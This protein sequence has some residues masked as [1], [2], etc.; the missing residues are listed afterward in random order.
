M[1]TELHRAD[2]PEGTPR[3][4]RLWL[5]LVIGSAVVLGAWF[6]GIEPRADGFFFDEQI[7]MRN[8][9][10]I[11]ETGRLQPQN[12]WYQSLS[13]L[14]QAALLAASEQV[15]EAT[16]WAMF[17]VRDARGFRPRAYQ[18]CRATT[19]LFGAFSLWLTFC[20]GRRLVSARVGLLATFLLA[21]MPW[22]L[23]T[24]ARFKP[25]SLLLLLTLATFWWI[26]DAEENPSLGPF[27]RAG[28]GVGLAVSTKLNGLVIA[29]PLI[30]LAF[31]HSRRMGWRSPRGWAHL[32]ASG[33]A[34]LGVYLL[35][36]PWVV[37]TLETLSQNRDHYARAAAREGGSHLAVLVRG[38]TTLAEPQFHGGALGLVALVGGALVLATGLGKLNVLAERSG[39][40][41]AKL[42]AWLVLSFPIGQVL[43]NAAATERFKE[44]HLVQLIPF[45]SL[46][47]AVA[48]VEGLRLGQR[49]QRPGRPLGRVAG[50]VVMA[51]LGWTG[52]RGFEAV[53]RAVVPTT[54][55]Q[56]MA[57]LENR[58]PA[59]E[60]R[61]LC[62]AS[63][64]TEAESA[65]AHDAGLMVSRIEG[66]SV[67]PDRLDACDALLVKTGTLHSP[68]AN[69]W[70]DHLARAPE[71]RRTRFRPSFLN[72]RGKEWVLLVQD[73]WVGGEREPIILSDSNGTFEA[74]LPP[75]HDSG[76]WRTLEL[77][78]PIDRL[79][80][81]W[82]RSSQG[83]TPIDWHWVGKRKPGHLFVSQRLPCPAQ[84]SKLSIVLEGGLPTGQ[85]L[86]LWTRP[87]RQDRAP[88]T[89][90]IT[91]PS[92]SK[93]TGFSRRAAN[94]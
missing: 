91:R 17:R 76:Q 30:V 19:L 33:A 38:I 80:A 7:P 29:I 32:A 45:T 87:W 21:F 40:A 53:Y 66:P 35:F 5:A 50:V 9:A 25:D 90:A 86:G 62:L 18:I 13:H 11:L 52:F 12:Y 56:A 47:A 20:L 27:L 23:F 64:A 65:V 36:N 61:F 39:G 89:S 44:N 75:C 43:I 68:V 31:V 93:R 10:S 16:G 78:V 1:E 42:L 41:R 81:A 15:W 3:W 69:P 92:S 22:H 14:P 8:I 24:S 71:S 77:R 63:P 60:T 2:R 54:F 34:A 83:A 26:L 57:V 72:S 67:S 46:W 73:G 6:A 59:S 94:P 85:T 4:P 84:T 51:M 28:L 82:P 48:M 88:R 79:A 74:R 37:A 49:Y 55:E 58:W 70:L